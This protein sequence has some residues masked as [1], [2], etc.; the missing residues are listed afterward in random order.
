MEGPGATKEGETEAT[1]TAEGER[2][3][4]SGA[5]ARPGKS[6]RSAQQQAD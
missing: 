2:E 1:E 4:D 5:R 6:H 3:E